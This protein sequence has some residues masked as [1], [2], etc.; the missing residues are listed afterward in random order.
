MPQLL[1][2]EALT[3]TESEVYFYNT[4]FNMDWRIR[5]VFVANT[6]WENVYLSQPNRTRVRLRF[7][8]SAVSE[9]T[10]LPEWE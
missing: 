2:T 3:S 9:R 1:N 6:Y 4:Y 5:G 7:S 8:E 10:S